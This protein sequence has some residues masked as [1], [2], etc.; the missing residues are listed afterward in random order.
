MKNVLKKEK[1]FLLISLLFLGVLSTTS[2]SLSA[3][4][5]DLDIELYVEDGSNWVKYI[6][7]DP[8][9]LLEFKI[10]VSGCLGAPF[11]LTAILPKDLEYVSATENPDVDLND[12]GGT[13]IVWTY[14]T[15]GSSP[16]TFYFSALM[17]QQYKNSKVLAIGLILFPNKSDSDTVQVDKMTNNPPTAYIDSISPSPADEG[18]SVAFSGT[19]SDT[20]GTVV[21]WE[22]SSSI[23]GVFGSAEDVSY[24]GLSVGTHTI[25]FRV[26][27]NDNA[28]STEVPQTLQI[29]PSAN[30]NPPN[31]PSKPSGITSGTAGESYKYSSTATD[32]DGDQ[33]WY[34]WDWGDGKNSGWL[35]PYNSGA[36]CDAL[37]TWM[38][39]GDY[40][41]KV[42][43]KDQRGDESP[44]SDPLSVSMPKSK[45]YLYT[46]FLNFLQN[47]IQRFPLL[48]K[49]LQPP[50]FDKLLYYNFSNF[51]IWWR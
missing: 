17:T 35:G 24:S 33:I 7:E 30:N 8:G 31:K 5:T 37:H 18:E 45:P 27:D 47:L 6:Q 49:L 1:V 50:M 19:G 13:N 23:D 9:T 42:K 20:D 36:V 44:W 12:E 39:E 46:P 10:E 11:I 21:A 41:V 29:D 3:T 15:C 38:E 34:M 28:W 48:A 43:A 2:N 22:W 26:K 51:I 32:P 25:S 40:N 4:N 16:D 14:D